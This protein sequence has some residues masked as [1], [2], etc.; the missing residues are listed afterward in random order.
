MNIS[1][2]LRDI[3]SP[4]SSWLRN[5]GAL[6]V[7]LSHLPWWLSSGYFLRFQWTNEGMFHRVVP[8]DK[9]INYEEN[10]RDD[11]MDVEDRSPPGKEPSIVPNNGGSR[12]NCTPDYSNPWRSQTSY[13]LCSL[14]QEAE[15]GKFK[16][17]SCSAK[18]AAPPVCIPSN[19]DIFDFPLPI[20]HM[21]IRLNGGKMAWMCYTQGLCQYHLSSGINDPPA[22]YPIESHK[23]PPTGLEKIGAICT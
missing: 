18:L 5:C 7:Y 12:N 13:L 4:S 10:G 16:L 19:D 23:A 21:R 17:W 9:E 11:P 6:A 1:G 8:E 22:T 20:F 14:L 2:F 15:V 3:E